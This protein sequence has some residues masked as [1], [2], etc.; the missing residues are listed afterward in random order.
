MCSY[1][2]EISPCILKACILIV[3]YYAGMYIKKTFIG[4]LSGYENHEAAQ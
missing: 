1:L 2:S 4:S 3:G